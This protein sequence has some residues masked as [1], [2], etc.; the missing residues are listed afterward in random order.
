M[1]KI[2]NVLSLFDGASCG[3]IALNDAN[4]S[5]ENYYASEIKPHAIA[6]TQEN[7]PGTIQLGD[8][9]KWREWNINWADVDLLIGGSPCQNLSGA[10]KNITGLAGLKSKLFYTY[11]DILNHVRAINPDVKFLCENVKMPKQDQDIFDMLLGA[12]AI[13]INSE[14]FTAQLRNRLYW[15]NI[16]VDPIPTMPDVLLQEALDYGYTDRRKA[17]CLLES[18]SRPLS[19]PVKMFHRYFATGFTTLIFKDE[20]HYLD[21][22][23]HYTE[24]YK[25]LAAKDIVCTSDV[26]DGVRYLNQNELERMQAVPNGF[27]KSL[28]RND[29]ACLTGD[30][31]TVSVIAYLFKNL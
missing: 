4:I 20:Q 16:P 3:Q 14:I 26:Y 24:N 30:G 17:R 8:V 5:F 13:N 27:T 1:K 22:K 6:T 18:D 23:K 25:G 29:A 9:T 21:C 31:W 11:V 12:S 15:T 19:T 10:N 28:S 7:F 2:K